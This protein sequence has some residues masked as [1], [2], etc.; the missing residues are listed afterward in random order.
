MCIL[1][2]RIKSCV[3]NQRETQFFD[4]LKLIFDL[5]IARVTAKSS[6]KLRF[7]F[8]TNSNPDDRRFP[9]LGNHIASVENYWSYD[10]GSYIFCSQT[11]HTK[12]EVFGLLS[13]SLPHRFIFYN[14]PLIELN[15]NWLSSFEKAGKQRKIGH[16]QEQPT[17]K[18]C[19]AT[20]YPFVLLTH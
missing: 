14:L 1:S 2:K 6:A 18:I 9:S 3:S 4:N 19:Y 10:W 20:Q 15:I 13:K 11:L 7:C 8:E 17:H 5:G 12:N 16:L